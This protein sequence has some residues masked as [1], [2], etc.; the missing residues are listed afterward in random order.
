MQP[1]CQRESAQELPHLDE[2]IAGQRITRRGSAE[3]SVGDRTRLDAAS[4]ARTTRSFVD[5][6]GPSM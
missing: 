2:D 1:E 4:S 3:E 5:A 6:S